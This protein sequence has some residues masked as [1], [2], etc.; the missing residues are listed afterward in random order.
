MISSQLN[1]DLFVRFVVFHPTVHSIVGEGV[2]ALQCN[3]IILDFLGLACDGSMIASLLK[4]NLTSLPQ[5]CLI[6]PLI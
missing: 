6:C 2:L 3:K 5:I 4:F 1:V